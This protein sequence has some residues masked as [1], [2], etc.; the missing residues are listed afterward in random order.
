M[1]VWS[2]R[3]G[4]GLDKAFQAFSSSIQED[5]AFLQHDLIG[6]IAHVR[7]LAH[8]G[9]LTPEECNDL[10]NALQALLAS[11]KDG[12][13]TLDPDLEDVHMNIE[14]AITAQLGDTGR[15]LHTGRSRNDQVATCIVLYAREH[16][17]T[18]AAGC[19]AVAKVLATQAE[20]HAS[21]PWVARTHGQPAQPATL[22]FLLSA[23]AW[24][25]ADAAQQILWTG[26]HISVSPL[27]S[28]AI[29]G[30]TLPLDPA[31]TADL[32]GLEPPMNALLGAGTRDVVTSVL[33]C[34]TKV[35]H[36]LSS[37]AED[38]FGLASKGAVA[39]PSGLTTGSSLMPQ[40]R[41]P[42]AIELVRGKA[43]GLLGHEAAVHAIVL[44]LGLGYVRDLQVV[45]PHLVAACQDTH[46]CLEIIH[47]CIA[48]ASFKAA[49]LAQDLAL[50]G[51]GATDAA[52]ALV[53]HG[54]PFRTAYH[55]VA[56]AHLEGVD[57]T[58]T[59]MA[60][61]APEAAKMAA[62]AALQ[63][64]AMARDTLGGPAP[65]AVDASL[66]RLDG[67]LATLNTQI[68]AAQQSCKQAES[69]LEVA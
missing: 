32:M 4:T 23:H 61:D 64:D 19:S 11:S 18:I 16:L 44:P 55:I 17:A 36:C 14:S 38:L 34:T 20:L 12:S 37:L 24:R 59:I 66:R 46:A 21:T 5:A 53:A 33:Q 31:Y 8:A 15:K 49:V 48:G 56:A 29:A 42:D 62:I 1:N 39:F 26:R 30:S 45:K 2:A 10:V 9:L 41:N 63:G 58:A 68:A 60:C 27:G 28:G 6:S 40:K 43:R 47:A 3:T 67:V 57:P 52:E 65:V 51:I 13:F 69:L 50:P 35:A 7:G 54:V 25:F 22:G